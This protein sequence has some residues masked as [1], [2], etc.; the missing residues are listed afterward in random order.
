MPAY[1]SSVICDDSIFP[2]HDIPTDERSFLRQKVLQMTVENST[3][4][5][6]PSIY[7]IINSSIDP[8]DPKPGIRCSIERFKQDQV[9]YVI[10]YMVY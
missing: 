7:P 9:K 10:H 1:M 6:Y 4:Y 3:A 8:N 5:F 2:H